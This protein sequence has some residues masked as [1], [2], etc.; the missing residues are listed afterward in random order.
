MRLA[1]TDPSGDE[2]WVCQT[3]G[4]RLLIGHPPA[5]TKAVLDP[6]DEQAI[7]S[8]GRGGQG[9]LLHAAAAPATY[10]TGG[11]SGLPNDGFERHAGTDGVVREADLP[12]SL[13]L[14]FR[15][16]QDIESRSLENL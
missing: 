3:C 6:G 1:A 2:E 9:G 10:A 15:V 14:W 5:F 12:E 8:G 13:R 7:H 4:R 11:F 16:I